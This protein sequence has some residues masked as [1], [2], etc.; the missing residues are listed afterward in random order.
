MQIQFS[1]I[2]SSNER[3]LLFA[4]NLVTLLMQIQCADLK[5]AYEDSC[6]LL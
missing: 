4:L 2:K 5:R 6:Y 1:F 3:Q